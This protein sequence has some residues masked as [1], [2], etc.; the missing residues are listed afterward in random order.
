MEYSFSRLIIAAGLAC[1]AMGMAAIQ[2][3]RLG[4]PL[5]K[6]KN[7]L[8]KLAVLIWL[9]SGLFVGTFYSHGFDVAWYIFGAAVSLAGC[10]V[11]GIVVLA[12]AVFTRR[13]QDS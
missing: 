11:A 13:K 8:L 2:Q 5:R 12:W 3:M 1:L 4:R 6:V 7:F 9:V 10:V